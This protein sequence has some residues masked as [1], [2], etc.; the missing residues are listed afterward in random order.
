MQYEAARGVIRSGDLLAWRGRGPI[1]WLIRHVTGGSH[2]H[3]GVAWRF[4][5]R[6][7]VLEAREGR[8]VQIR[9][10]SQATP[11]DWIVTGIAWTDDAE[12][13]ALAGLGRPYSYRDA[14]RTAFGLSQRRPGDICSEYAARVLRTAD[15][16]KHH[17]PPNPTPSDLVNF[18]LDGGAPL[19]V[20]TL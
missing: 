9:A 20:V 10:L 11:F 5:G 16:L 12:R 6:L 15:P 13:V 18:F 17:Y 4:R 14:I 7:F 2:T 8:G 19:R 3:A 1:S